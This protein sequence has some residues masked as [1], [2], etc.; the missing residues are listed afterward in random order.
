[1]NTDSLDRLTM[2]I[3][4]YYRDFKN[5]EIEFNKRL[6]KKEGDESY[7]NIFELDGT[8]LA[9]K[10]SINLSRNM[11]ETYLEVLFE[12]KK[13]VRKNLLNIDINAFTFYKQCVFEYRTNI[14]YNTNLLRH[15]FGL[16]DLQLEEIFDQFE[17]SNPALMHLL[18][19]KGIK[20]NLTQKI[21]WLGTPAQFGWLMIE[22]NQKGYIQYPLT[23]NEESI[24]KMAKLCFD[25]F[26]FETKLGNTTSGNLENELNNKKNSLTEVGRAD[27]NIQEI[28]RQN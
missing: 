25:G 5:Q 8:I 3:G 10:Y 9:T 7:F 1:M 6:D 23:N 2:L 11:H 19:Q 15:S 22:L 26:Q 24:R 4:A 28:K 21:K 16:F 27:F 12:L 17:S 14:V 20:R 13:E 18:D